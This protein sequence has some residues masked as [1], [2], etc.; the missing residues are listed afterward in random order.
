M[1][2]RGSGGH[3]RLS[4]D[5]KRARGTFRPDQSDDVY[6]ARQ[7]SATILAGPW[8]TSIP[9]PDFPLNDVG[10]SKYDEWTNEL[11]TQRKLTKIAVTRASA[12]ALLYQK[13]AKRAG[14]GKDVSASDHAKFQSGLRELDIATH[15]KVTAQPGKSRFEG[16]GFANKRTT[17]FRLRPYPAAGTGEL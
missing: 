1:G 11:F 13:I 8:L 9:E 5:E 16:V 6:D 4:D 12:L 10:R 2:G 14:E 15:A 7:A 3:N 17:P